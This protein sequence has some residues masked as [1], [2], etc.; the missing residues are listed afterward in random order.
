MILAC[1]QNWQMHALNV[2]PPNHARVCSAWFK[3]DHK[4]GRL[5][6]FHLQETRMPLT[7]CPAEK[8]NFDADEQLDDE[9]AVL[10]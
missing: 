10:C 9:P 2:Q 3:Q 7:L 6:W 4:S 1:F 8:F 5:T